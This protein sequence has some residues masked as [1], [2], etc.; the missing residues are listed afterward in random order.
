MC[1]LPKAHCCVRTVCHWVVSWLIASQRHHLLGLQS[2]NKWKS[3]LWGTFRCWLLRIWHTRE[4]LLS[5][6]KSEE[7]ALGWATT[8]IATVHLHSLKLSWQT[9]IRKQALLRCLSRPDARVCYPS[10][11]ETGMVM[12][13]SAKVQVIRSQASFQGFQCMMLSPDHWANCHW[14]SLREQCEICR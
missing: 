7:E 12:H 5:S 1:S 4:R 10:D 8:C 11:Q 3:R 6:P 2:T 9:E 14:G 13:S